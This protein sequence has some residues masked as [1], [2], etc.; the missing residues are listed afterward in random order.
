LV[1]SEVG[2][3]R[4]LSPFGPADL[5]RVAG[6]PDALGDPVERNGVAHAGQDRSPGP[7]LDRRAELGQGTQAGVLHHHEHHVLHRRGQVHAAPPGQDLLEVARQD[8]RLLRPRERHHRGRLRQVEPEAFDGEPGL[9]DAERPGH[10]LV[11][12]VALQPSLH[13]RHGSGLGELQGQQVQGVAG[14]DPVE[15]G[16]GAFVAEGQKAFRSHPAR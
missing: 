6:L 3:L 4:F 11:K 5:E 1:G 14:H 9:V 8:R 10:Q 13:V 16:R 12:Q 2:E 15:L 7:R